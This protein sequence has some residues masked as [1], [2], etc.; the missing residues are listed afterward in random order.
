MGDTARPSPPLFPRRI[1]LGRPPPPRPG[2]AG[3]EATAQ[4]PGLPRFPAAHSPIKMRIC[5]LPKRREKREEMVRPIATVARATVKRGGPMRPRAFSVPAPDQ[6]GGGGRQKSRLAGGGSA[7]PRGRDA[8]G[9]G[10]ARRLVRRLRRGVKCSAVPRHTAAAETLAAA[11]PLQ[12]GQ[13]RVTAAPPPRAAD[14][15]RPTAPAHTDPEPASS[16]RCRRASWRRRSRERTAGTGGRKDGPAPRS[17]GF[18]TSNGVPSGRLPPEWVRCS[19]RLQE[20]DLC[21]VG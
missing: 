10:A 14:A 8:A 12:R 11:R 9:P 15:A 21:I 18:I 5:F 3:L 17:P 20:G 2:K 19:P 1:L 7:E 16:R 4:T 13:N 6:P